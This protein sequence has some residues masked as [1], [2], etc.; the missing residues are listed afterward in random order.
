[1]PES[2]FQ[3]SDGKLD[4]EPEVALVKPAVVF[5]NVGPA[6]APFDGRLK[7][8]R[9][10]RLLDCWPK[11]SISFD[12]GIDAQGTPGVDAI[13]ENPTPCGLFAGRLSA[14]LRCELP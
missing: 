8:L 12:S 13:A 1:M 7:S 5:E 9:R 11:A 3:R 4:T 6:G 10:S 14:S 2:I